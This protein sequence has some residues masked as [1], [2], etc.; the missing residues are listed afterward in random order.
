MAVIAGGWQEI[1]ALIVLTVAVATYR[2]RRGL[3][4]TDGYAPTLV[5]TTEPAPIPA[6]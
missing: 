2:A 3:S 5:P 1:P 4:S 6:A